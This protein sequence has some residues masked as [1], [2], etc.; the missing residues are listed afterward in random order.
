MSKH[1]DD[2]TLPSF[3]NAKLTRTPERLAEMA[4]NV[5]RWRSQSKRAHQKEQPMTMKAGPK[6]QA[7]RDL[8]ASAAMPLD[9]VRAKHTVVNGVAPGQ[10]K[11]A[12]MAPAAAAKPST[13]AAASAPAKSKESTVKTATAKKPAA[14]KKAKSAK[15]SARKTSDSKAAR[16][17][18]RQPTGKRAEAE[19]AAHAGKLPKAPDFSA[20]THARFRPLLKQAV[21]A[22]K[23]GEIRAL[24]AIEVNPVSTSPKAIDRYRKLAIIA[25]EAQAKAKA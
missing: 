3:L 6:E 12:A 14:N 19:A 8:K 24:K 2:L 22:A 9:D 1:N 20:E 18:A 11:G 16:S 17:A 13:E 5:A 23:A 15:T 4:A 21:E 10:N 25:L 7:I